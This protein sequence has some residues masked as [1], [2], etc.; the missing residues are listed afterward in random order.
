MATTKQQQPIVAVA[1]H[2]VVV[3]ADAFKLQQPPLVV[4][5]VAVGVVAQ[6]CK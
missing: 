4:V 5:V 1:V 6:N 2:T 3:A